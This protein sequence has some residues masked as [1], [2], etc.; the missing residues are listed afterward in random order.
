M[1]F[2]LTPQDEVSN[3]GPE[4]TVINEILRS[5]K[6]KI[7]VF[8]GTLSV[9]PTPPTFLTLSGQSDGIGPFRLTGLHGP[10]SVLDERFST[11]FV[12]STEAG[13][14]SVCYR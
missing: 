3:F 7:Q 6:G 4:S 2:T 5:P 13:T 14:E 1:T 12:V 11:P 8:R 10:T 9:I